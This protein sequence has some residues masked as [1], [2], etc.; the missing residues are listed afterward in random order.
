MIT[1]GR[2]SEAVVA[3]SIGVAGAGEV[4]AAVDLAGRGDGDA[5]AP[6]VTV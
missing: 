3:G 1:A 5:A 4:E 2:L 6:L